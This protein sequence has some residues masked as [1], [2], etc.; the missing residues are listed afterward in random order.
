MDILVD[1]SVIIAV[2]I[3]EKQ[4]F[5]ILELTQGKNLLAPS[6]IQNEI[7]KTI[8]NMHKRQWLR[9]NQVHDAFEIFKSIPLRILDFP[10][11]EVATLSMQLN[12]TPNDAAYIYTANKYKCPLYTF[13]ETLKVAANKTG[14]KLLE[15]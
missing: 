15:D 3:N 6:V 10:L 7:L 1:V 8:T 14:V 9:Q 13:D 2:I 4:K 11:T 12:I 5:R